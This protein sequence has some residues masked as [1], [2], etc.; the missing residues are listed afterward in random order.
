[1]HKNIK[2]WIVLLTVIMVMPVWAENTSS[3]D[4]TTVNGMTILLQK[5]NSGLAEVTLL[6]KSGS[7]LDGK[8]KGTAE[9]M[10]TLVYLKLMNTEEQL[11]EVDVATAPDFTKIRIKTAAKHLMGVLGEV[12]ALLTEPLYS[13][14]IIA[15]LKQLIGADLKGMATFTKAYYEVNKLFYGPDHPYSS[16]IDPEKIR[17]ISGHDVYTWYRKTYQPGNAI[18]S[19]SGGVHQD[20][21]DLEKYFARMTS[22]S[23]DRRILVQPVIPAKTVRVEKEDPNGRIAS[24]CMS[25]AAPRLQDPEYPAFRLIAYYLE[26]YQHYFEEVRVKE[27]LMYAGFVYYSYLERPQAPNIV[28]LTMTD[29][30]KL[31]LVET[32]TKDIVG[33]LSKKG[34]E[35][36]LIQKVADAMEAEGKAKMLSGE[37]LSDRNALSHY[38]QNTLVNDENL[39]PKLKKLT[40]EDI[41]KAAAKYFKNYVQ[42]SFVPKNLAENFQ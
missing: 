33:E 42:V 23:V 41:K 28:F 6:L 15:D 9:L 39:W 1:M 18:L 17:N 30:E 5:T 32:K 8:Q 19:I 35:Q 24:L 12:K 22:E 26:E 14:D 7:G 13:Y 31:F 20:I 2:W 40:T 10:N 36:A 25:Y 38:F 4:R 11:G 29:S 34:L 27:G 37:G 3:I 21:E 16:Q